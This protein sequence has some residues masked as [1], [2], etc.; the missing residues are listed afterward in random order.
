MKINWNSGRLWLRLITI[1]IS[2]FLC[3]FLVH[4]VIYLRFDP[5]TVI[6]SLNQG[7][8]QN[9]RAIHIDGTIRPHLFP[10]PGLTIKNLTLTDKDGKTP[11]LKTGKINIRL[12]WWSW[13]SGNTVV[14]RLVLEDAS[15]QAQ[16]Y[17]D[18]SLSFDDILHSKK[19]Q[20]YQ[21]H[22]N[23]LFIRN[24]TLVF[25]DKVHNRNSRIEAINI[26]AE[27]IHDP[28]AILN[29]TGRLLL[30]QKKDIVISVRS[31]ISTK[32]YTL[33]LNQM[34]LTTAM[35]NKE[36]GL[37]MLSATGKLQI[38]YDKLFIKG[39][40]MTFFLKG[41][42]TQNG[43]M[44]NVPE[45]NL[46]E[47][48]IR[49]KNTHGVGIAD[50]KHGR[51]ILH[52]SMK[53]ASY[54]YVSFDTS[55][56]VGLLSWKTG[57][58][59]VLLN[60][61]SALQVLEHRFRL[62]SLDLKVSASTKLFPQTNLGV[63]KGSLNGAFS[64]AGLNLI[65]KGKLNQAPI[66]FSMKQK[67]WFDTYRK[68]DIDIAS[69]DMNH[70]FPAS[71]EDTI[72]LFDDKTRFDFD[73]M[74]YT[75]IDTKFAIGELMAGRFR[76]KNINGNLKVTPESLLCDN[77]RADVYG[78]KLISSLKLNKAETITVEAKQSY[79]SV[80]INKLFF[81]LFGYRRITGQGSGAINVSAQGNTFAAWR[82]TLTGDISMNLTNGA[83]MG[84]DLVSMLKNLP[85]ELRNTN[86]Q[87][88]L[89]TDSAQQ[90]QFQ[91]L[92]ASLRLSQGTARN[93]NLKLISQV[94]DV[95]GHGKFNLKDG[96]IDYTL[97]VK[98]NPKSFDG[99][100]GMNVPIKITGPIT[101]PVYA[102]DFN[103]MVKGKTTPEERQTALKEELKKQIG[104]MLP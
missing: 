66:D 22:L 76:F 82:N 29:A 96:I 52:F 56:I 17:A 92:S 60:L 41:S 102:L 63:I 32:D 13:L 68:L 19:E 48:S 43:L 31:P 72:A 70:F 73:W 104:S 89:S 87:S 9:G 61:S 84:I 67:G 2:L 93:R 16:R 12:S 45:L 35:D 37:L 36:M 80:D 23:S 44:L 46:N 11:V 21:I 74:K 97:D 99:L 58:Q 78:G 54:N 85:A 65:G 64:Q 18:G 14:R 50:D 39:K 4:L 30:N 5:Q 38:N 6:Q 94:A 79:L 91:Q 71:T 20:A 83:L 69:L 57:N 100:D 7:F 55:K 98:A 53:D 10:S 51:Y 8:G 24:S 59:S 42:E 26:E 49:F 1:G 33:S 77:I 3:V 40:G 34:N 27:G 90:T 75:N 101:A 88:T 81:D 95:S 15:I 103:A 62:P 25:N 28:D 47:Q 86:R